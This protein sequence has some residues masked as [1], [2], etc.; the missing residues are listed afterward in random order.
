M[1]IRKL[2]VFA[3]AVAATVAA[4]VSLH[5]FEVSPRI[6][7][8]GTEATITFRPATKWEKE[9]Y[10]SLRVEYVSGKGRF[11]DGS[12]PR[13]DHEKLKPIVDER[14]IT[15]TVTLRGEQLHSFIFTAPP[16]KKGVRPRADVQSCP[17]L[18]TDASMIL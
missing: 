15:V 14:G 18:Q 4:A 2:F 7:P 17:P 13:R 16:V 8:A 10:R 12:G 1:P 3:A 11:S 6:Y 9:N 5:A